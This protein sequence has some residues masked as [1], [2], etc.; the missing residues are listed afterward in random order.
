[1]SK[2]NIEPGWHEPVQDVVTDE[3]EE[4]LNAL[5]ETVARVVDG[6][7]TPIDVHTVTIPN[8]QEGMPLETDGE[9][10]SNTLNQSND[11]DTSDTTPAGAAEPPAIMRAFNASTGFVKDNAVAAAATAAAG[12]G[13]LIWNAR[14]TPGPAPV[15]ETNNKSIKDTASDAVEKVKD[16]GGNA[17]NSIK[18]GRR[19]R[20]LRAR[21]P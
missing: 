13:W 8:S 9:V 18:E 16:A 12:I 3:W 7:E 1:M 2:R 15:P 4:E 20:C 6:S 21:N 5:H 14:A 19:K 10:R 17:V 11:A